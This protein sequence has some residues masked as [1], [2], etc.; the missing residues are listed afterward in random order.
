MLI[1]YSQNKRSKKKANIVICKACGR[2]DNFNFDVPD[3]IW[4]SV[5]PRNLINRV[6]CITCF[7]V[8]ANQKNI[9]YTPHIKELYFVGDRAAIIFRTVSFA[10]SPDTD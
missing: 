10:Y 2:R 8:F 1:K 9:D 3:E 5:V 4:L 7:D 6:V